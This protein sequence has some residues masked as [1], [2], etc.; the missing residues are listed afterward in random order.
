VNSLLPHG[1]VLTVG[2]DLGRLYVSVTGPADSVTVSA[3]VRHIGGAALL[4]MAVAHQSAAAQ[5]EA[6]AVGTPP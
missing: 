1:W 6:R 5:R 2:G 3:P 4:A